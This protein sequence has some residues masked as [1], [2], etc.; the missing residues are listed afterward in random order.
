MRKKCK[1]LIEDKEAEAAEAVTTLGLLGSTVFLTS[2][3]ETQ[4]TTNDDVELRVACAVVVVAAG[5]FAT[6]AAFLADKATRPGREEG[7][8][9]FLQASHSWRYACVCPRC[10]VQEIELRTLYRDTV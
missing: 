10:H 9:F 1:S 8:I 2:V 6:K 4:Y 5:T 7:T 3:Y